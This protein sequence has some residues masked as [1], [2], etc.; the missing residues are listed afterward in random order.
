MLCIFID[1]WN[2]KYLKHMPFLNS[3]T[4]KHLSGYLEVPLGYTGIIASFVTG[5]MPKKHGIFDLFIPDKNPCTRIINPYLL[6]AIR[7]IQNKRVFYTPLRIKESRYFKPSLNKTWP[8]KGCLPYPTIFDIL[9][10][11]NK[12]FE[13]I[14]WPNHFKNRLP[15]IIF[16]KSGNSVLKATKKSKADFILAHF[17]DLEIS[18]QYGIDSKETIQAAEYI[19][20]VC[21]ELYEKDKDILFFSDHGMNDIKIEKDILSEINKLGLKF[22]EDLIYIVGSTT[23]EFWFYNKNAEKK[24]RNLLKTLRYGKVI[25]QKDFGIKTDSDLIFLAE[26]ETGFHPNFFSEKKFKSMHGWNPRKQKTFYILKHSSLKGNKT[27]KM[28]DFMPTILDIMNLPR[29]DCDGKS[30]LKK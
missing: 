25:N 4:K 18:H 28:V 23:V 19:D 17:L 11:N 14:D 13:V 8:Q 9:E 2:P 29:I 6:A 7:I 1:A 5:V 22:A 15:L 30:L 16:S 3:L 21:K 12:T 27:A 24:V 10:K 20:N 26:L